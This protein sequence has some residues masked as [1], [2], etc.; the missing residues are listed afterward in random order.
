[1]PAAYLPSPASAIWHLGTL[2]VRTYAVCMV[3]GVVVGLWLTNRRY[4]EAGGRPGVILDM[5]T[6]AVPVGLVGARLYSVLTNANR[7]FGAGRDWTDLLRVWDGGMGVAGAVAAG[8]LAAWAYC[9]RTGTDLGP[10]A[11]AAAPALAVAQ[12]ISVWGNWFSQELYGQ[13]VRAALGR[14]HR[15][16]AQGERLPGRRHL[17]A[18]VPLRVGTRP[19]DRGCGQ[20]RDLAVPAVRRIGVR[21][22]RRAVGDSGRGDRGAARGLLAAHVRPQVQHARHGGRARRAITYL[23]VSRRRHR[24]RLMVQP[25]ESVSRQ[26]MLRPRSSRATSGSIGLAGP[27]EALG[28]DET[29]PPGA[30]SGPQLQ[31]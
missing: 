17:P 6:V 23:A 7:Y 2:P 30:V 31:R 1:M 10:V 29:N 20:L 5:A 3:I 14:G 12:A 15:T 24:R 8:A 26:R 4:C 9:R 25:A 13:P 16:A 11:L 21:A 28:P 18:A 27:A 19:A 22:V